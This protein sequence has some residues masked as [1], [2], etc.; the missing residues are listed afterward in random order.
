MPCHSFDTA[1]ASTGA[2]LGNYFKHTDLRCI[3]HM[4]AAAEFHRETR[5][6]N[7]THDIA[8]FF[9]KQRHRTTFFSFFNRQFFNGHTLGC[10]NLFINNSFD[11]AQFFFCYRREMRKV[12]TQTV[13]TYITACL[14]D[15]TA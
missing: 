8:I 12:E 7:D 11:T 14:I 5:Y 10:Q 2:G 1:N 6:S 13:R 3:S 15:M 9:A 4:N